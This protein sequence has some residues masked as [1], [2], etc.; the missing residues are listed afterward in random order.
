LSWN[1]GKGWYLLRAKHKKDWP[2]GN[3]NK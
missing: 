2:S 1:K 3:K